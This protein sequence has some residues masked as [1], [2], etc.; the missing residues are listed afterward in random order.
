[1]KRQAGNLK[2]LAALVRDAEG[3]LR[4]LEERRIDTLPAPP[5]PAAPAP[6]AAAETRERKESPLVMP[7][8][9]MGKEARLEFLKGEAG[10]C[11]RC[12]LAE[13]RN[14]AVFGDG[15]SR[16]RVMFI[17]EGPGAEEDRT[18]IPFVGRAGKLLDRML[19]AI[20]LA[21]S[22]V[23]IANIVKCRPPGNRDPQPDEVAACRPFLNAQIET[24]SPQLIVCLGRPS[25]H[26]MLGERRDLS[27]LRGTLH[28]VGDIETLV[29]YHPA[30]LLR[31]PARKGSA[32]KDLLMLVDVLVRNGIMEQPAQPWWH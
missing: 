10:K 13:R 25:A 3:L 24:V 5:A 28:K 30:F 15:S 14:K 7:P 11:R 8:T 26:S 2:E 6:E 23:Y 29:T 9:D 21:R 12:R 20:G 31:T 18:G 4:T 17:G 22:D 19:D 27:A 32:W 16:A 1:M